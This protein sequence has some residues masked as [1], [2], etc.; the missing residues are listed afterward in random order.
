MNITCEHCG[1]TIDIDKDKICPSCGA[2]YNKNKEYKEIKEYHKKKKEIDLKEKETNIE[3]RQL[4]NKM[5]DRTM[6]TSRKALLFIVAICAVLILFFIYIINKSLDRTN[7]GTKIEGSEQTN[8]KQQEIYDKIKEQMGFK[9]EE[10][11]IVSF[12]EKAET[13]NFTIKCNKISEYKYDYFEKKEYKNSDSK[14]YNFHIV[15]TNKNKKIYTLDDISL[16][17]EDKDGNV[18]AKKVH[19]NVDESKKELSFFA[20]NVGTYKGNVAFEIPKNVKNV[21]IIFQNVTIKID[22]FKSKM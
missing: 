20:E 6:N 14:V 22:K 16:L 17:Y 3:S 4:A 21:H 15:F 1:A 12:D 10:N 2:P 13:D 7:N 5:I 11:I 18:F 8:E 9:Q 19:A